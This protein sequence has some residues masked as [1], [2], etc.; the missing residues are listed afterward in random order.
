ML[1]NSFVDFEKRVGA[2]YRLQKTTLFV[3]THLSTFS[4]I[5]QKSFLRFFP[6]LPFVCINFRYWQTCSRPE[7][8]WNTARWTLNNYQSIKCNSK[9]I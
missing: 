3:P 2:L 4:S 6:F 7:Y 1:K 8:S 9:R 5:C